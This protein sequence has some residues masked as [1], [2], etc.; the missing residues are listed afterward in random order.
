MLKEHS[1]LI[2][3]SVA[4]LDVLL[5]ATAYVLSYGVI[6]S[7]QALEPIGYYWYMPVGFTGFY[8]Y[9]AWTRQLFSVLQFSWVKGIL[10]RIIMIFISAEMLGAAILYFSPSQFLNR[11]LYLL[12][13]LFS[14]AFIATEKLILRSIFLHTRRSNRHTVPILLFGRGRQASQIIREIARQPESGLRIVRMVDLSVSP[15]EFSDILSHLFVEEIFFI[16][17][18]SLT[19]DGFRIDP[20]L[21]VCEQMGRTARV[22]INLSNATHFAR[23]KYHT[24]MDNPTLV[25]YTAELDPDQLI[26]KR[27]FDICGAL[28]GTVILI[29]LYPFIATLIKLTSRGPVLYKQIRVGKDGKRFIMYKFRSMR[30]GAEKQKKDLQERNELNGAMFKIKNDPRTTL[31]GRILR[32]LSLDELPQFI[33]VLKGEMSLVGTRPPLP[34]EIG[35]YSQWHFRRI[36]VRPGL[37]GLWQV[38]GRSRITNFDDIVKLDLKYIDTWSMWLDIVIIMRTFVALLFRRNDAY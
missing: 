33:N 35:Q 19:R 31:V 30:M 26:F 9:F 21:Q 18:R 22:F 16:I 11:W 28:I 37:T 1:Y 4:A 17:P 36:C 8:L 14:F 2:K 32:R 6:A 34:E 23:W 12:F 5:L 15:E 27:A 7:F 25:S 20:Y 29:L 10:R 3:Q 24:F 13:G 38:S